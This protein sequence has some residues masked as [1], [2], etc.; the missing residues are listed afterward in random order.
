VR[1]IVEDVDT[2]YGDSHIL[3]GVS[4]QVG[5]GEVV[6]L[7]GRNGAGKTTT[8]RTITGLTPARRGHVV[9][10]QRELTSWA[11]HRIARAGVG[12]VPSGRRVFSSLTVRQNLRLAV[13]DAHVTAP[14]WTIERL[15]ETFPKL[16]E[17]DQ[18]RAGFLSGGEQQ[19][20]KLGRALLAHPKLLLL[21]EPTEG[22]APVVVG[23]MRSWIELIKHERMSILLSEQN[24]L[25]ALRLADR[26]YILEKGRIQH[27][28]PAA[29]L[30]DSDEIRTYLGVARRGARWRRRSLTPSQHA[31]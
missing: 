11:P 26:G 27:E 20:L 5:E 23:Q 1:L 8:M 21:D 10:E 2:Y 3:Q 7:L 30:S 28:A 6:A 31:P 4:L 15:H 22:L 14:T 25:F 18:R 16:R 17:L 9:L 24:A 29:D 13:R 12:Y 19:M